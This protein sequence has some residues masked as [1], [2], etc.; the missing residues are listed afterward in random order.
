MKVFSTQ[1]NK[2]VGD[3]VEMSSNFRCSLVRNTSIA[4]K[5]KCP[6]VFSGLLNGRVSVVPILQ[7]ANTTVIADDS[8]TN[9]NDT[10]NDSNVISTTG[11]S[12][13]VTSTSAENNTKD[14]S[15]A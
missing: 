5:L 2:Q 13:S 11:N 15:T 10:T 12:T 14:T 9:Q 1:D 3:A 7:L 4:T 8:F 6:L